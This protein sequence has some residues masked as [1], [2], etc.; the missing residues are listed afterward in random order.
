MGNTG[1]DTLKIRDSMAVVIG[2]ASDFGMAEAPPTVA[3]LL[4]TFI[5][6]G[7]SPCLFIFR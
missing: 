2:T 7:K 6:Y 1:G 5:I 4:H 3:I